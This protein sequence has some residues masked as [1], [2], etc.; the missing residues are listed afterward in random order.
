MEDYEREIESKRKPFKR[1]F[2]GKY[3]K[4]L[5]DEPIC[6]LTVKTPKILHELKFELPPINQ[7]KFKKRE[8]LTV[9]PDRKRISY[10]KIGYF[11]FIFSF[12][13]TL[14]FLD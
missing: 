13:S 2:F 5:E 12:F 3:I 10:E 11:S 4:K 1:K 8:I 14:T 7:N 6:K 9:R